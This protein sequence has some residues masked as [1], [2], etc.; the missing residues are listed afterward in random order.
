MIIA[1]NSSNL[2]VLVL[3]GAK[4][5]QV[6]STFNGQSLTP[7]VLTPEQVSE[8]E[9]LPKS[10]SGVQFVDG[11]FT[12]LPVV[13]VVLTPQ[14]KIAE[15][16]R[17]GIPEQKIDGGYVRGIREYMLGM[18]QIVAALGGPDVMVTPGMQ[19]V[20]KLDDA[21]KVQRALIQ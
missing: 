8:Y 16:E 21:I 15:M 20:K 11:V 9:A 13:P 1:T 6:P 4:V 18:A 7:H 17:I 3:D 12:V 19:K 14:Q 10:R 5:E 2:V